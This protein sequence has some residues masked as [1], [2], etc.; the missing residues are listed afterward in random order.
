MIY[1]EHLKTPNVRQS[2]FELGPALRIRLQTHTPAILPKG[3]PIKRT[4]WARRVQASALV[5]W[6]AH[7]FRILVVIFIVFQ[8]LMC[9]FG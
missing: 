7:T 8:R 6:T 4:E 1:A 3:F 2:P 9:D 5:R